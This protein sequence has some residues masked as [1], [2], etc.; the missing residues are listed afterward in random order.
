MPFIG[1]TEVKAEREPQYDLEALISE[2]NLHGILD[3][4]MASVMSKS[5]ISELNN[6][7]VEWSKPGWQ[8]VTGKAAA[9][10]SLMQTHVSYYESRREHF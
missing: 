8:S 7:V 5:L 2:S 10:A 9:D 6:L 3:R 1:T 4:M